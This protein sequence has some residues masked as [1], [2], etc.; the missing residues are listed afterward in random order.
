MGKTR[1][2]DAND[3]DLANRSASRAVRLLRLVS[4]LRRRRGVR[5]AEL[6]EEFSVSRQTIHGYLRDLEAAD[7]PVERVNRNGEVRVSL[8]ADWFAAPTSSELFALIVARQA[9][10]GLRGV[11][12]QHWVASRLQ[13]LNASFGVDV[14]DS[15][16]T[17]V[18]VSVIDKAIRARK[19]LIITYRG[20]NDEVERTRTV[21]PLSLVLRMRNWYLACLD[22]DKQHK[23]ITPKLSRITG[24][25]VSTV[26]CCG[27][28]VNVAEELAHSVGIWSGDHLHDVVV[29][30][31]P[32][33]ARFVREYP[34]TTTQT[35]TDEGDAVVVRARV[36]GLEEVTRWLLRWGGDA[37]VLEP[38]ALK[39]RLRDE[40]TRMQRWLVD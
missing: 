29:R 19:Q 39:E 31:H 24:A 14:E 26:A 37:E 5:L 6:A 34:L 15:I 27:P 1:S 33:Q 10:R 16:A 36:S 18:D 13:P 20:L 30:V 12:A 38:A 17:T 22:V 21:E 7:I 23:L 25:R 32:P 8:A 11:A 2:A 28:A 4:L 40:V 3:E 35:L 9:L